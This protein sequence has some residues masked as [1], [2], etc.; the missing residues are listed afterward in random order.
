MSNPTALVVLAEGAEEMETVITVD[1][2]RRGGIDVTVAGLDGPDVVKC[3]R[4]VFLKPDIDLDSVASKTYDIVICP[5]G[6]GGATALAASPKMKTI[7]SEQQ[8]SDRFVAAICAGPLAFHSHDIALNKKVTSHPAV[9]ADMEKDKKFTY[10]DERVVRDE[11]VITS[12]GPGT[13]FEF[14]LAIVEALQGK[15][16]ADSIIPPMLLKL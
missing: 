13:C 10:C 9:K 5:G 3:S 7:L 1:V 4:G 14:S 16:K 8:K 2:L 11:K 15:E 6:M 12:Q